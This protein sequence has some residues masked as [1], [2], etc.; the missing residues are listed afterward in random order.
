MSDSTFCIG[1]R[2]LVGVNGGFISDIVFLDNVLYYT[3][4]IKGIPSYNYKSYEIKHAEIYS[5]ELIIRAITS[6]YGAC[7]Q[8]FTSLKNKFSNRLY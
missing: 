7:N 4:K 2:V 3:V 1:D 5:K 6:L 8:S